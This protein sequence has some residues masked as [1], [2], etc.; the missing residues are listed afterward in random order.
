M[1]ARKPLN[2]SGSTERYLEEI[3]RGMQVWRPARVYVSSVVHMPEPA[4]VTGAY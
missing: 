3:A 4:L 2:G 1:L